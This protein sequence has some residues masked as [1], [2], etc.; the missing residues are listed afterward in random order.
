MTGLS[1]RLRYRSVSRV[2]TSAPAG[3]RRTE[4]KAM[5][6]ELPGE[7]KVV[8]IARRRSTVVRGDTIRP[9]RQTATDRSQLAP[10]RHQRPDNRF[11]RTLGPLENCHTGNLSPA[12]AVGWGY[13]ALRPTVGG[14]RQCRSRTVRPEVA[15][16]ATKPPPAICVTI[17]P[18]AFY[19]ARNQ[20]VH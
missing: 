12:R 10:R 20:C 16:T 14:I 2:V 18:S 6:D 3:G 17:F 7:Y 8:I 4:R 5:R 19:R 15:D 9:R 11:P 1:P 13:C